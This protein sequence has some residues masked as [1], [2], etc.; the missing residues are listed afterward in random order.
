[1]RNVGV[2]IHPIELQQLEDTATKLW[3]M[4]LLFLQDTKITHFDL[5]FF[6]KREQIELRS[7]ME[8]GLYRKI[9]RYK[10]IEG[11]NSDFTNETIV[12]ILERHFLSLLF[13]Q[14]KEIPSHNIIVA[15]AA[16]KIYYFML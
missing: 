7:N 1:M 2:G 3:R 10:P 8:P 16:G 14:G 11:C 5:T 4:I 9:L 13:L 12:A 6:P 15:E